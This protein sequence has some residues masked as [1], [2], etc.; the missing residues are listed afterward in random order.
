MNARKV[1]LIDLGARSLYV[2]AG[3]HVGNGCPSLGRGASG[4]SLSRIR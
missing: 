2:L 3:Q 4:G 1:K